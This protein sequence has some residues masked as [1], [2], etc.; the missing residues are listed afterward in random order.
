MEQSLSW[1]APVAQLLKNF[2]KILWNLNI[3]YRVYNGPPLVPVVGHISPVHTISFYIFPRFILDTYTY[4]LA[5]LVVSVLQ[6]F[7][8]KLYMRSSSSP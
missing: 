4:I 6:A 2:S 3:F 1:E 5:F 7:P 8:P